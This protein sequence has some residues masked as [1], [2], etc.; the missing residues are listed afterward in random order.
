MCLLHLLNAFRAFIL[1][2]RL[3]FREFCLGNPSQSNEVKIAKIIPW[4]K[5]QNTVPVNTVNQEI[6][7]QDFFLY[8]F[9]WF[10]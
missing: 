2:L 3:L 1:N 8:K 7:I 6:V 5:S 9:V 10:F 4:P